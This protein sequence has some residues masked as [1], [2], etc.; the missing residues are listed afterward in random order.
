MVTFTFS[1]SLFNVPY[2]THTSPD[3]LTT[4][5]N[6]GLM[7]KGSAAETTPR[8]FH[9]D[10]NRIASCKL[11]ALI[12]PVGLLPASVRKRMGMDGCLKDRRRQMSGL[13]LE[14]MMLRFFPRS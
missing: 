9:R 11:L 12:S 7:T 8:R 3:S 14:K 1:G 6:L 5:T 4:F 13:K 10:A 2:D